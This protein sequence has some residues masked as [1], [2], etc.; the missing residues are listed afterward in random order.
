LNE[1]TLAQLLEEVEVCDVHRR[2]EAYYLL[3][4]RLTLG[5]KSSE[6]HLWIL[7]DRVVHHNVELLKRNT[8]RGYI[9]EN[10]RCDLLLL[11]LLNRLAQLELWHVTDQLN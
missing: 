8:T 2:Y 4:L 7:W 3:S 1:L 5:Y 9:R 6:I 11:E 10:E